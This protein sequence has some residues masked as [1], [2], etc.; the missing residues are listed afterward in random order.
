MSCQCGQMIQ[1]TALPNHT[2]VCCKDGTIPHVHQTLSCYEWRKCEVG[3]NR[4]KRGISDDRKITLSNG[5]LVSGLYRTQVLYFICSALMDKP[6]RGRK[7]H[8]ST[9]NGNP[10]T[11]RVC[12]LNSTWGCLACVSFVF[13]FV[14]RIEKKRKVEKS[15]RR[16]KA[17]VSWEWQ[18]RSSEDVRI[19]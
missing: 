6:L 1:T 15:K 14:R 10:P 9:W 2:L 11:S 12:H 13:W 7:R 17:A 8:R 4:G 18:C 19:K 5:M 3:Q 16:E